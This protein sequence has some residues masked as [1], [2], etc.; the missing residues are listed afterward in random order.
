[1]KLLK[2][3]VDLGTHDNRDYFDQSTTR[4]LNKISLLAFLIITF[5]IINAI[6]SRN[7][8]ALVLDLAII[9]TSVFI[10]YFN[11]QHA[12]RKAHFTCGIGYNV[13]FLFVSLASDPANHPE[14]YLLVVG[15]GT[16]LLFEKE[17]KIKRLFL[18]VGLFLWAMLKVFYL[19]YPHGLN[20]IPYATSYSLMNS[21]FTFGLIY[22]IINR[23][24]GHKVQFKKELEE[25][26]NEV[27]VLN[28]SLEAKVEE[29]TKTIV[30]KVNQINRFASISSHDL[31]EPL[32]NIMSYT[33]L[34]ERDID[35]REYKHIN[36]YMSF[37]K[38]GIQRMDHLTQDIMTYTHL[39]NAKP[40]L[41][42]VDISVLLQKV[43][44][45]FEEAIQQKKA[46]ISIGSIPTLKAD[47]KQ[48]ELLFQNLLENALF[49]CDKPF[50]TIQI[51]SKRIDNC[52][53]FEIRDNGIGID[54]AYK[55]LIFTSFKR[56]ENNAHHP[57][58]GIGLSI[59]RKIV[60]NHGGEIWFDSLI[61]EG[62]CFYFTLN[63]GV[64]E[65]VEKENVL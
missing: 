23:V 10:L 12:H 40:I 55:D 31:R 21:F 36:E 50:P 41:Q 37:V 60:Q 57:G 53:Q 45:S 8:P 58:S 34:I 52:W 56:L 2:Q 42:E 28:E 49:Y 22:F 17:P 48:L 38:F 51:D 35:K 25:Q 15:V 11:S 18:F 20:V 16:T 32:R 6:V 39:I 4:T 5:Y 46:R 9:V 63:V 24:V 44:D 62:S 13:T 14:F 64:L 59:C 43:M 47:R 3:L 54:M 65:K 19:K 7:W 33:Q 1:M 29:K 27:L 61:G 30:E 26:R